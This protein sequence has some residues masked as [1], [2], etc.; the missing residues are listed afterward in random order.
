MLNRIRK[1]MNEKE[2]G[3]TLIELLVVVIIIGILAAIAIPVFL[4]QRKKG[5]DAGVKSDARNIA[6]GIE[7]HLTD[8]P[9]Y[10]TFNADWADVNATGSIGNGAS[11]NWGQA[12]GDLGIRLTAGNVARARVTV[13]GYCIKVYNAGASKAVDWVTAIAYDSTDGGVKE[14]GYSA[15]ACAAA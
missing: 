2:Q 11:S 7:S 12:T 10:Q 15:G 1:A 5:V 9:N 4:S 13:N 3:F 6:T 8:D 14:S